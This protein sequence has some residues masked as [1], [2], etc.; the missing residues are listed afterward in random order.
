MRQIMP[1]RN[2]IAM[3]RTKRKGYFSR[4]ERRARKWGK[5]QRTTG[6]VRGRTC[7][8]GAILSY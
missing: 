2:N 3:R 6:T 4:M 8:V 7:R 5:I 1:H